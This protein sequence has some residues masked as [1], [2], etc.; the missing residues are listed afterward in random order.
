MSLWCISLPYLNHFEFSLWK[1]LN[2]VASSKAFIFFKPRH[3]WSIH[4]APVFTDCFHS[5]V[6]SH[7]WSFASDHLQMKHLSSCF[8]CFQWLC[9]SPAAGLPDRASGTVWGR[10]SCSLQT[11]A[12]EDQQQLL[13]QQH[14]LNLRPGTGRGPG[15]RP[16]ALWPLQVQIMG[17]WH[18]YG[19]MVNHKKVWF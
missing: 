13:L 17:R 2:K 14:H 15:P 6:G 1:V 4:C 7:L 10:R 11:G 5:Y 9:E 18:Q 12:P 3:L 19:F 8:R 16:W